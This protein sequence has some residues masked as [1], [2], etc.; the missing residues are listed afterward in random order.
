MSA[1]DPAEPSAAAHYRRANELMGLGRW[2]D[3]LAA[4]EEALALDP[5]MAKACCNRG[6]ALG[7]LGRHEDA[8]ASYQRALDIE[9]G[10][11]LAHYNVGAL[12]RMLG[13]GGQ[14]LESYDRAVALRPEYAEAHFNRAILLHELGRPDGVISGLQRAL[15][16]NPALESDYA[17]FAT[18]CAH[19][20]LS[21]WEAALAA[22]ERCLA[23]R[24]DHAQARFHHA[25][26]LR[27]L[28][29]SDAALAGFEAT[30]QA[31]PAHLGALQQH[32]FVLHEQKRYVEAIADF[33]RALAA[34]PDLEYLA[35]VRRYTK[36]LVCDWEGLPEDIARLSAAIRAGQRAAPPFSLLALLDSPALLRRAT[37]TWAADDCPPDP[38]LGPCPRPTAAPR[39]RVGYFSADFR[40]HPVS[41]LMAGVFEAHDRARFETTAFAFGPRAGDEMRARLQG[42]FGRF[43]DVRERSDAEVATLAR[44]LG[45]DIAVDLGGFTEFNRTRIFALRAAPVQLGYLGFLGTMGVP[46]MDY[47]VAADSLVPAAARAH[48]A[49]KLIELP[50][51]HAN[52]ARHIAPGR[53]PSRAE[54][55]IPEGAFV[56][57]CCNS[58][59]K[60]MPATFDSWMRILG[61]VPGSVLFLT[62]DHPAATANLRLEAGRRGIDPARIIFGQRV[63][64]ADYLA[65]YRVMDVFLDTLP[66][67][68]GTTASDA[69]WSGVPVVTRRGET[70]P[71]RVAASLVE[72]L[73]L[74]GLVAATAQQYEDTAVALALEPQRLA[75]ARA[76]LAQQRDVAPLFSARLFT[77]H[78]E[79]AYEAIHARS[80]AGLDPVDIRIPA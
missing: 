57:A 38:A 30:L 5:R 22:F 16:L 56:Y 15:A 7:R 13:R 11:A 8:L 49:E 36:M 6:V 50:V 35:G 41:L 21:Q 17:W 12:Q 75:A 64:V 68:A 52:D 4:Y 19:Q 24:A 54:L 62:A 2:A 80:C 66:Y 40:M 74:P 20:Q 14:A 34:K 43:I 29:R 55:G 37:E 51:Y 59:Y 31:D 53:V 39:I 28:G 1:T 23:L 79:S 3:A 48:Y 25:E 45:I 65:R 46:Y 10:D 33:D 47:L 61:R 44:E 67:N 32:G 69:L 63:L 73:G 77:R 60:I 72:S 18:G 76:Q 58:N 70:F 27:A 9:P 26:V 42:A 71:A 78:L